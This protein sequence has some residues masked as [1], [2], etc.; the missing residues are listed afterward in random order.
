MNREAWVWLKII[1]N[2]LNRVCALMKDLP[3]DIEVVLKLTMLKVR[4]NRG[5]IYDFGRLITKLCGRIGVL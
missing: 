5:R 1:L 2:F 4:F 3:I